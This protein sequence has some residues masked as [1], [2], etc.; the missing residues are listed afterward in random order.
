MHIRAYDPILERLKGLHPKLIDLALD[1]IERLLAAL[2]HP[3]RLLP[4]VVHIAGTNGKGSTLAYL[5]AIAEAAGLTVHVYTSPHLVRFAERIRVAGE[6]IGEDALAA[7]LEECE[8]AN[9]G[10]PITFF[11][12]T[13]AAAFLAFA[14]RR[15]DLCLLETGL[16]GRFDA[17][18]VLAEPALTLLSPISFDHEAFL[19]NTLAAIAG[20]KAGIVKKGVPCLSAAQPPE[21]LAVIEARARERQAPLSLEG[22][23]WRVAPRADGMRFEHG[24]PAIDLPAPSL[25]GAHQFGN[26]GL[27]VAAALT[28][29]GMGA[30]HRP[31]DARA[32][33]AGVA[34]ADWPAR[35]QRLA[36][37]PLAAA[38]PRGWELWLDG[39][40]NPAAGLALAAMAEEW[41]RAPTALPLDLIVGMLDTKDARG[42]LAPFAGRVRNLRTVT[43]PGEP[44]AVPAEALAATA[45]A[46]GLPARAAPGVAAALAGLM[47]ESR[48][49]GPAR[50]L[51][52][53]SLYLAGTVLAENG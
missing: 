48:A 29:D 46:A 8:R 42:F 20:E 23:A 40:H 12:V 15:A 28:L 49:R 35:L 39:G 21:A 50:V 9:A 53:G 30:L 34:H 10:Q 25:P 41:A 37:G 52:A 6:L 38:L 22:R 19:G 18:N 51:I 44:H 2:G 36:R 4:P 13:T 45:S 14:R 1:R 16:G 27:A 17:T 47:D 5:R 24:G 11:E 43:I 32:L 26:A 3:E 7:I 33:A 31:I